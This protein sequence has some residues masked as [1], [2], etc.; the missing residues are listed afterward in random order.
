MNLLPRSLRGYRRPWLAVDIVAGV[1]VA[2]VAIGVGVEQGIVLAIVLSIIEIIR[3]AYGPADFVVG[4]DDAG[5]RTFTAAEPG[6]QSAPG[7]VVFRYD[8]E[9]F[10]A[11]A[12]RFTDDVEAVVQAAPDKVRWLVLDCSSISDVDYSAGIAFAGLIRYVQQQA[13]FAIAGADV[14]LLATLASYGVLEQFNPVHV[15]DTVE[16]AIAAYRADT[17]TVTS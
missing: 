16:E 10:Y 11:N 15:F 5:R 3:G 2:A 13:H 17:A 8:E 9:L 4:V 6:A 14:Q 7:L 1:T 12:S